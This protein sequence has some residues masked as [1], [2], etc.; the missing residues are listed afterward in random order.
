MQNALKFDAFQETP[1]AQAS[2]PVC[3]S[4]A[5]SFDEVA[6]MESRDS[7]WGGQEVMQLAE[8]RHCDHRWTWLNRSGS[9]RLEMVAD[10]APSSPRRVPGLRG[11]ASAA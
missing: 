4:Q 6:P 7:P 5:L 10:E 3:G 8:C 1:K 11:V 2:C 9:Q